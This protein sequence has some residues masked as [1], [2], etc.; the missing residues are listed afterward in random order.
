MK[1]N[2]LL[3]I[4]IICALVGVFVL[5]LISDNIKLD[6]TAISK[7]KNEE[8]GN[9]V[10]VKGVVKDVFNGEKVSIITITQPEE[11]KVITYGNVSLKEGDYI[12]VI[13]EIDEYNGNLELVGNRIRVV[14]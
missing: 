1:E 3:K 13:G 6:E 11:M 2:T 9:N 7:I 14:S 10:K 12:E 5:Y 4:S 8:I